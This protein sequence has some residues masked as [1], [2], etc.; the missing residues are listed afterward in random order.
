MKKFNIMLLAGA[1]LLG[2]A[3]CDDAP[4]TALP[5]E[6]PQPPMITPAD[7]EMT[8]AGDL[9]AGSLDLAPLVNQ[10]KDSVAV[11]NITKCENLAEG[12]KLVPVMEIS[13]TE[14]FAKTG[15]FSCDVRDGVAYAAISDINEAY[16]AVFGYKNV[17]EKVYARTQATTS[18]EGSDGSATAIVGDAKQFYA[19]SEFT[20]TPDLMLLL[21]VPMSDTDYDVAKAQALQT[22]DGVNYWGYVN[23]TSNFYFTNGRE[24]ELARRWDAGGAV[25]SGDPI[26]IHI[27]DTGCVWISYNIQEGQM[28]T[29]A[30]T[31]YGAIGDL[32]GNNWATSEPLTQTANPLIWKGD[33]EFGTGQWKFRANDGW[34]IN[35]GGKTTELIPGGDNL[36]SPGEGTYTVT[37]DLS[38]V[39][40]TTTMVKK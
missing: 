24:G 13:D 16:A 30:I 22:N 35:L 27:S 19:A 36:D 29:T 39:P 11:L 1:A 14:D 17:A 12:Y 21:Y 37:L 3:A 9:A 31:T 4:E 23:V 6:N 7:V 34:D 10:L 25:L 8:T 33:I 18:Y 40:Y 32:P 2:F 38:K 28:S 5:Q 20:L 26:G 15:K